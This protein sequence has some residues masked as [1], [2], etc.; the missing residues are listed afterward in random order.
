MAAFWIQP[1]QWGRG[2]TPG[3][4]RYS[5]GYDIHH[6]ELEQSSKDEDE[7]RGHPHIDGLDVGHL[8]Q[9]G[10]GPRAH[11]GRREYSQEPDADSG[12]HCVHIDPEVHPGQDDDQRCGDVELDK[13]IT[14]FPMQ[15]EL[16]REAGKR[17]WEERTGH[18]SQA[19]AGEPHSRQT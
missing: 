17:A 10:A 16:N 19:V 18:K 9:R 3:L 5:S 7:T 4:V 2:R 15:I 11:C 6:C 1:L 12:W 14:D 8:G 13:E